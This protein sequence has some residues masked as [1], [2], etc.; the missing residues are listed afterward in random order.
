MAGLYDQPQQQGAMAAPTMKS[1]GS[2]QWIDNDVNKYLDYDHAY[3][4]QCVDLY[5]FYT[6]GFV[7]GDPLPV[8]TADQIW[9]HYDQNAYVR[10]ASNQTP[11]M[12]DVAVYGKSGMTPF[13]HVGIVIQDNGDGT[14]RTLS[15]NATSA[16]SAGNSAVVNISKASLLGYL[17]PRKLMM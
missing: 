16:G 7:G 2:A 10:I 13:S 8:Q 4:A 15:N 11:Q 3:G 1:N 9:N 5:A 12:G 6:T 17:R 14:T